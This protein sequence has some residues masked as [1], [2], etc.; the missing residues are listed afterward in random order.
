M[1]Y[2]DEDVREGRRLMDEGRENRLALGDKLLAVAGLNSDSVFEEFCGR[3][4]LAPFTGR[5]YRHTARMATPT[6]RQL[7]AE[8][9]VH[10]SYSTL[11]E[12]ARPRPGG[13]PAD[14]G[15]TKLRALLK[16]AREAGRDRVTLASYQQVLGTAPALKELVDPGTGDSTK[17]MAYLGG[18]SGGEREKIVCSLLA[19][20][21][22]LRK[23]V[24]RTIDAQTRRER[25]REDLDGAEPTAQW[26]P[27]ARALVALG[28]QASG[29]VNR[30]PSAQLVE[31]Q[32]PAAR[33]AL[34]KLELAT[35]W[36]TMRL[37]STARPARGRRPAKVAV[38]V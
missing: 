31:Q 20:D 14:E 3:I 33:E 36:I 21:A 19:D 8:G 11:R 18:L 29:F 12:G 26:M 9:G 5:E 4:G 23:S 27:L 13:I 32:L 6:I 30:H 35:A 24:R 2:T 34:V 28:D 22:G 17:L 38:A 10:V 15:W 16:E 37:D 25:D 1:T 7:I